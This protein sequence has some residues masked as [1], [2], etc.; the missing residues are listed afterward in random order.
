MI[1]KLSIRNIGIQDIE[2]Q[3]IGIQDTA[4]TRKLGF[5]KL[6]FNEIGIRETGF[7]KLDDSVRKIGIQVINFKKRW[8]SLMLRTSRRAVPAR[9]SSRAR[10]IEPSRVAARNQFSSARSSR[11]SMQLV[12]ES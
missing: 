7:R 11:A 2:I 10:Y 9:A 8:Y 4:G 1:G 12:R 6:D 5:M 3:K